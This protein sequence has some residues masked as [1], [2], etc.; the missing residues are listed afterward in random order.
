MEPRVYDYKK[1]QNVYMNKTAPKA[2]KQAHEDYN[3]KNQIQ[4]IRKK[5]KAS[6][7][8]M[9]DHR[10][11]FVIADGQSILAEDLKFTYVEINERLSKFV[12]DKVWQSNAAQR[13]SLNQKIELATPS[14]DMQAQ[15]MLEII[16]EACTKIDE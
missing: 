16:D 5:A 9:F 7:D 8:K 11:I 12:P 14:M 4:G 13:L 10:H 3:S 1:K 2:M 15:C 6:V